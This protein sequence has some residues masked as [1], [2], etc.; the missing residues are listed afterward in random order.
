[1]KNVSCFQL[2]IDRSKAPKK[3]GTFKDISL[4]GSY[5][6]PV[7]GENA[8]GIIAR[9]LAGVGKVSKKTKGNLTKITSR[10]S[11][12]AGSTGASV[13]SELPQQSDGQPQKKHLPR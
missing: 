13:S 7:E 2:S 4:F 1:M 3:M 10:D 6:F 8:G 5:V 11:P 12:M 9:S